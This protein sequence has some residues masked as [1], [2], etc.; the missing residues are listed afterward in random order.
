M[1]DRY[2]P[3]EVVAPLSAGGMGEVFLARDTRLQRDVALKILPST[4]SSDPDRRRRF[5]QEARAAGALNHPGI[6]AIYDVDLESDVPFLVTEL[7]EGRTLRHE[8]D[9]GPLPVGRAVDFAAQ[10]ADA[11]SAAHAIGIVHRD[12]KPENVM[13]TGEG[14]TKILDFGLAKTTAVANSRDGG[15]SG[16]GQSQTATSLV[17]GTAP[18]MS[19]EQARGG[20]TDFRADQFALGTVL[21]E[22]L[23]GAHPFRRETVVQ[24]LSA[25][26]ED[27]PQPLSKINR[28]VP[29]PVIWVVE[30][31][32]SKSPADRYA[33]TVDLARDLSMLRLRV[34]DAAV[35]FTTPAPPRLQS[36]LRAAIVLTLILIALI[37][38]WAA[39]RP[40]PNPFA[41]H[42]I[43]PLA[44]DST[45]Q[46]APAW[47]PDGQSIAFVA[48]VDGVLQVFTRALGAAQAVPITRRPFDCYDPFWSPAGR[49]VYFHSPAQDKRGL[50]VVSAA[51]EPELVQQNAARATISPDGRSLVFFRED[52]AS[53]FKLTLWTAA[54]EPLS[55]P[56]KLEVA[57][58]KRGVGDGLV[59]F[60]PDGRKLL[61]WAYDYLAA[62]GEPDRDYLWL[63]SWP[64]G[65]ARN[66]LPSL[67][68][69][70]RDATIA[71]DWLPD[72][73][74][75]V[76]S[77][78]DTQNSGRHL[79]LADTDSDRLEKLTMSPLSESSPSVSSDGLRLAFTSEDVDF[80]LISIPGD[81][82]SPQPLYATSRNE[83]DPA[84]TPNE[85]SFAFVTDRSGPL[86]LV[87]RSRD[88]FER[89]IVYDSQFP[90]DETWALGSLAFSPN[91]SRLAYQRLGEKSGYRVWISTTAAVSPPVQLAPSNLGVG[92]Q[93][94]PTWA[95]DGT[96]IAFVHG[97]PDIGWRLVKTR[98]GGAGE[99]VVL[100][101]DI[102]PWSH[103][104]WSPDGRAILFE[105][106]DGLAIIDP[107]TRQT[108][109]VSDDW[110]IAFA[111][112]ADSR[113]I[114][115]L[116]E[117]EK[118]RHFM[119]AKVDVRTGREEIINAD[120]GIIPSANQPIRGFSRTETGGWVT[121]V[122]RARSVIN[123]L[124]GF[125]PPARGLAR[126]R[127]LFTR[128]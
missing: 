6:V 17:F 112:S 19:P 33:S 85:Q 66:I 7:I 78:A 100:K 77:L 12:L 26:I 62:G 24:T 20:V 5:L 123:M 35:R 116:R 37:G 36:G 60:A 22:M 111:W 38:W 2:G 16:E 106:N 93:D 104:A 31:C 92:R 52:D 86:Q 102:L 122:A 95:P 46:G 76:L 57:L 25:I 40:I 64:D 105:T 103:P 127:A 45:Y 43:T 15:V 61:V 79:W 53:P 119:L 67:G 47:S 73:R 58:D 82:S 110:W 114:Y 87:V 101:E 10:L 42:V 108:R 90:G 115:G 65:A 34:S 91:G 48:Q 41:N 18:Y 32:L 124:E 80:D 72:S 21:Y 29:A 3:Y 55:E 8:V 75:V 128:P 27:D 121:S 56:R 81:G 23:A 71:F 4:I 50:W 30:R 39:M 83:F 59:R 97:R 88:G 84:W 99:S 113:S 98:V 120:L 118:R 109:P 126:L 9:R 94:A 70:K 54:A 89:P 28:R 69:R 63:I 51:G 1:A 44:V 49:H 68:R 14:R 107:D 117:A 125:A 11:L 13:V 96:W 74:H